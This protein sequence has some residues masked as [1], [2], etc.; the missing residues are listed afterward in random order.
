[1]TVRAKREKTTET[2]QVYRGRGRR[3]LVGRIE[4]NYYKKSY[5]GVH[6]ESVGP[7]QASERFTGTYQAAF[8]DALEWI[9]MYTD[10]S[11]G[12]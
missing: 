12:E 4:V 11:G 1:M 6:V 2:W 5:T 3:E 8:K 10:P 7:N 9:D